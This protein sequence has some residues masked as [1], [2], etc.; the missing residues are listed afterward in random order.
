MS[1]G[2]YTCHAS[3][4]E[5]N[6][7]RVTK[8]KIKGQLLQFVCLSVR[9]NSSFSLC[10]VWLAWSHHHL[11][12][13]FFLL[14]HKNGVKNSNWIWLLFCHCVNIFSIMISSGI[15]KLFYRDSLKTAVWLAIYFKWNPHL[16]NKYL[17]SVPKVL[18]TQGSVHTSLMDSCKF[19][20][21]KIT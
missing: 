13:S 10:D 19:S 6:V 4:S 9:L 11:H 3:N 14:H 20:G 7:T 15:L 1:A 21:Y 8:V 16:L 2:Q 5:G 18:G 17:N 12:F